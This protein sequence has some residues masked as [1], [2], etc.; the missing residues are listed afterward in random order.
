[1]CM[2]VR[3]EFGTVSMASSPV[4]IRVLRSPTTSTTPVIRLSGPPAATTA[5]F[6]SS[7]VRID[8][9]LHIGCALNATAFPPASIVMPWLIMNADGE[10][11]GVTDATTP[12]GSQSSIVSPC[13]PAK[14]RGS[15]AAGS[16]TLSLAGA[17]WVAVVAGPGSPTV[18]NRR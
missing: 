4:R 10:F 9:H 18:A 15:A 5:S 17:R 13:W 2:V 8:V 6:I 11:V 12:H 1:M 16:S 3:S 14:A 7:T